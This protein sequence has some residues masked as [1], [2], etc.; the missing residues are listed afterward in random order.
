MNI[1]I[2]KN[3]SFNDLIEECRQS[4][5]L[6]QE[7]FGKILGVSHAAVS[8]LER[9]R[10]SRISQKLFHVLL[11]YIVR[12]GFIANLPFSITKVGGGYPLRDDVLDKWK[13]FMSTT[14]QSSKEQ[15]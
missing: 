7:Q 2:R 6:S 13:E 12:E 3:M 5:G 9:G 15:S 4:T 11:D 10:T 8:D 1:T 14:N